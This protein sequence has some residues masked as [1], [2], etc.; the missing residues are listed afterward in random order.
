[1]IVNMQTIVIIMEYVKMVNVC[2]MKD[3]QIMTAQFHY[4]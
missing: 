2:A 4:V 1:M 3:G